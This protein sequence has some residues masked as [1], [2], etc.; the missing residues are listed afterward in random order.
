MIFLDYIS[1]GNQTAAIHAEVAA[2]MYGKCH[3]I[4]IGVLLAELPFALHNGLQVREMISDLRQVAESIKQLTYM[5][6]TKS[7]HKQ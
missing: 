3:L 4:D 7:P 6:K 1:T 2:V 5:N